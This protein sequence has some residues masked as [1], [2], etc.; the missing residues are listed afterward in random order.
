M[1]VEQEIQR[2][3]EQLEAGDGDDAAMGALARRLHELHHQFVE[4]A[5]RKVKILPL[6]EA[7]SKHKKVD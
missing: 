2:I 3:C 7:A 5:R 6:L 4:D 1:T